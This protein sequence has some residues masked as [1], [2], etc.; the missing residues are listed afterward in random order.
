MTLAPKRLGA[1]FVTAGTWRFSK[2]EV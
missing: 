2:I 1:V